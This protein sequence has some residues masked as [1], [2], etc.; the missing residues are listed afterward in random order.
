MTAL[1]R[2]LSLELRALDRRSSSLA[3]A[4]GVALGKPG[5]PARLLGGLVERPARL[6]DRLLGFLLAATSLGERRLGP[7]QVTLGALLGLLALGEP[8]GEVLAL[9]AGGEG[10]VG[11][12]PREPADLSGRRVEAFAVDRDRDAAERV[13]DVVEIVHEPGIGQQ[14]PGD[15]GCIAAGLDQVEKA[16][17]A[18]LRAG[19]RRR[20][21][22]GG[23][24]QCARRA[25]RAGEPLPPLADRADDRRAQP[26]TENCRN[27]A[28]EARPSLDH[29]GERLVVALDSRGR[30]LRLDSGQLAGQ[31]GTAFGGL[32]RLSPRGLMHLGRPP[33][34]GADL[35]FR[36]LQ[37][38]EDGLGPDAALL[39][40]GGLAAQTLGLLG[41]V[42]AELGELRLQLRD[43]SRTR[44]LVRLLIECVEA[45]LALSE[46]APQVTLGEI[47]RLGPRADALGGRAG[48]RQDL[49]L[50][51]A[52]LLTD[53]DPLLDRGPPRPDLLEALLDRIASGAHLGELRLRRG[54]LLLLGAKVV[55]D[56]LGS[57]LVR[58]AQ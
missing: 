37:G 33:Q 34:L 10:R 36:P 27:R 52:A 46:G 28:L 21:A 53:R 45:Q 23:S 55:G 1:G 22:S 19:T 9:G 39:C 42:L 58:L 26:L 56:D 49:P 54:Q 17:G 16:P 50:A 43:T 24:Q 29:P 6:A 14:P 47:E 18:F 3:I 41:G 8:G 15:R 13:G 12:L 57:K 40:L 20:L 5:R 7:L 2:Q 11:S 44:R 48:L 4:L 30:E 32:Q 51:P 25:L 35:L 31:G 38:L